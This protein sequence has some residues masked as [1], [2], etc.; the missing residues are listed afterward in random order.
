MRFHD[1]IGQ[2]QA[3]AQLERA[4]QHGRLSHAYIFDG[5]DG[6]GKQ[7]TARALAA[8]LLCEQPEQADSCGQCLSC[9]QLE[10]GTHP[11]CHHLAPDGRSIKIKQIRDLRARLAGT[12]S[13]G[14]YTVVIIDQADS[15]TLE[16]ANAFL[17]TVE[18]PQGPTCFILITTQADRLPDTIRSRAQ[19]VRFQALSQASLTRLLG[20]AAETSAG[21]IAIDLAAGSITRAR[22][23]L[24]D[25]ALRTALLER[26][27]KLEALLDSLTTCHDGALLRFADTF[28]G[29]RDGVRDEILLIRRYYDTRLKTALRDGTDLAPAVQVLHDTTTALSRL[30]T[31][32][33]PAFILGAL[34]IE[35]ARHSRQ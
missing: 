21:R 7:T 3:C 4:W 25:E 20:H 19:L 30:E 2:P 8:L 26:R 28:M 29:D 11:D 9:R 33:E 14:G 27:D 22:Q 10:A 13:Y 1:I 35:M 6:V 12:A 15:M 23:V 5:P 18:E 34:L 17:K 31:N 32:A 24:D 16:A